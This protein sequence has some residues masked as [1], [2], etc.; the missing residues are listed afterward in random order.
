MEDYGWLGFSLMA[1]RKPEFEGVSSGFGEFE[2]LS[3]E[4]RV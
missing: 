2:V 4:I 1:W 3:E